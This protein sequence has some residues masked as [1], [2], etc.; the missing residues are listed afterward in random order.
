VVPARST[1][2]SL[3][4]PLRRVTASLR[5]PFDD[6]WSRVTRLGW[7]RGLWKLAGV[8]VALAAVFVATR[9]VTWNL[10]ERPALLAVG[11]CAL[12]LATVAFLLWRA[13]HRGVWVGPDGVRV[14][15]LLG[16]T[17]VPWGSVVA[18]RVVPAPVSFGGRIE[19]LVIETADGRRIAVQGTD[20]YLHRFFRADLPDTVRHSL[21]RGRR[22]HA[23]ADARWRRPTP[24]PEADRVIDVREPAP[25]GHP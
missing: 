13:F 16:G 6:R 20:S 25:T 4:H 24:P 1:G 12:L 8:L 17:V 10:D 7:H 15:W 23:G 18:F 9:A 21:E 11:V 3:L 19:R 2:P 14:E 22:F 5:L